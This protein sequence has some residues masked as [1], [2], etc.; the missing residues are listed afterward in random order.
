MSAAQALTCPPALTVG[1]DPF[2]AEVARVALAAAAD[3]EFALAGGNALVTHDLV[4]RET[5]DVDLFS[6]EPGARRSRT[7]SP[8]CT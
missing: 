1:I 5:Q 7:T 6:P 3:R 2:Q 8:A 4:L